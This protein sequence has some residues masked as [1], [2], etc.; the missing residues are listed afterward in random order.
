M[1][2]SSAKKLQDTPQNSM[3]HRKSKH[4]QSM[5]LKNRVGV[6]GRNNDHAEYE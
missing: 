4:C 2:S 6:Y 3:S 5:V 1:G